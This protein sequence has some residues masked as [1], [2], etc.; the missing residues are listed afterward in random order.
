MALE[1]IAKERAE[2]QIQEE[3]T[4]A[5]KKQI[6]VEKMEKMELQ[7]IEKLKKTQTLQQKAYKE[8]ESAL[9]SS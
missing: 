4:K 1:R 6:Q 7:L 2:K 9:G 3:E 8:L 5:R